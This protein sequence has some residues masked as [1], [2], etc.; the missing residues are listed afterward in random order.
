MSRLTRLAA[1]NSLIDLALAEDARR[2]DLT[3]EAIV[4]E[5]LQTTATIRVKGPARVAGLPLVEAVFH[6]F[7]PDVQVTFLVE[8]G[9]DLEG[10]TKVCRLNGCARSILTAERTALNFL[11]RLTGIATMTRDAVREL[12]GTQTQLLDTRKTT[13]GWRDLEKYAVKVGGGVNHRYGLDDMVLIKDNHIALAGSVTEAIAKA[14]AYVGLAP[15][16][17]V[18]VDTLDQLREA[19]TAGADI[20]LLDNMDDATLAEAVRMTEGRVPLEASGNV[21]IARL[22]KIAATGVNYVSMGAL[23]HQAVSADVGLDVEL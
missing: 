5:D 16:I 23:T 10:T 3:S 18:E 19:L 9:A 15:K 14:R 20:I 4:P 2:G 12:A 11:A 7:D 22:R 6:R 1:V 13:P 17:E 8:E 21:T